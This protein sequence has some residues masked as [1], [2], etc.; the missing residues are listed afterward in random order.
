MRRVRVLATIGLLLLATAPA[1]GQEAA[2]RTPEGPPRPPDASTDAEGASEPAV[3][4]EEER[5]LWLGGRELLHA[6]VPVELIGREEG[7][8]G[9]REGAPALQRTDRLVARVDRE[10]LRARRLAMYAEGASFSLPP[11]PRGKADAT[12]R[13]REHPARSTAAPG[14]G[15]QE[16]ADRSS[17]WALTLVLG[18][19]VLAAAGYVWRGLTRATR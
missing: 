4:A 18:A 2:G 9:F 10:E 15:S 12:R 6:G 8:N 7:E 1:R 11:R 5:R 17:A 19:L 14:G 13:V 16:A 3:S